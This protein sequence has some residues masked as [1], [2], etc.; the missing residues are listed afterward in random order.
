MERQ[1]LKGFLYAFSC[2]L[3]WAS[4]P[5]ALKE[6]LAFMPATSILWFRFTVAAIVLGIYLYFCDGLPRPRALRWMN[7]RLILP[8]II[9]LGGNFYL[10]NIT[11]K[12]LSPSATQVSGQIIPFLMIAAGWLVF[13]EPLSHYQKIGAVT[14]AIGL[15][16]FFNSSLSSFVDGSNPALVKGLLLNFVAD[17]VWVVY[18]VVQKFLMNRFYPQQ[19][20]FMVYLGCFFLLFAHRGVPQRFHARFNRLHLPRLLLPQ[21]RGFLYR[22]RTSHA[23]L[24]YRQNQRNDGDQPHLHHSL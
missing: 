24:E 17:L 8:A 6:V 19:V 4:L 20:L 22:L 2:T 10:Y 3:F 13:K 1:P 18:A 11:L 7:M 23:L 9:C 21:Y 14:L 12:Y 5:I 16:L 15:V